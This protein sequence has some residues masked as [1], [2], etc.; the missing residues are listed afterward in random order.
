MQKADV[1]AHFGFKEPAVCKMCYSK[2]QHLG[3]TTNLR[4]HFARH[5]SHAQLMDQQMAN[6][7]Q[8]DHSQLSQE[9]V[10]TPKLLPTST[11]TTKITQ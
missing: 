9:Q 4:A 8:V 1:W 7:N 5:H 2:L 11:R 3:N 10:H 6:V